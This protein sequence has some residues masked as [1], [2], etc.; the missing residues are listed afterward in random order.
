MAMRGK[1]LLFSAVVLLIPSTAL[2]AIGQ[3][4]GFSFDAFN[5]VARGGC[6]GSAAG[7]NAAVIGQAQRAYDARRGLAALQKETAALTQSGSAVGSG[8]AQ[9]VVQSASADGV[10]DQ[11]V[12]TGV[13]GKRAAG[14]T[15]SIGLESSI[16]QRGAVGRTEGVQSFV[17]AQRQTEITPNGVSTGSQFVRGTQSTVVS[18]GPSSVVSVNNG[19]NVTLSRSSTVTGDF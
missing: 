6:V 11:L 17:G 2:A 4:L 1:L 16:S 19:L 9:A 8:G 10:Q 3:T 18:G 13:F 5:T 14:Q 15:F 7:Q 12:R